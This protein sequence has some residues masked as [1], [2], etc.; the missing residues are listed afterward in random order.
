MSGRKLQLIALAATPLLSLLLS[1]PLAADTL[2]EMKQSGAINFGYRADAAPFSYSGPDG[3]PRGFT[4]AICEKL[5]APL[6]QA[7]GLAS[8]K[9]NFVPVTAADRFAALQSK[10]IDI[11][12]EATTITFK[13]RE[14]MDF[15]LMTFGTG[16]SVLVRSGLKDLKGFLDLKG[17]KIGVLGNTTT[18]EGLRGAL[19]G[20]GV[21]AT[22]E[23]FASHDLGLA[24]IEGGKIDAYFGDRELL[25]G[26]MRKSKAPNQ[27]GIAS[28]QFSYEPYALAMRKGEDRLRLAVDR[29]LAKLYLSGAILEIIDQNFGRR[30]SPELL[31]LYAMQTIPD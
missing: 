24:A 27:L 18:E 11:L 26:L 19:K 14:T 30:P 10:K 15:S 17:R 4:V 28:A 23:T 20:L 7:A 22:I 5:V 3:K 21:E 25:I 29:A 16:A 12:C 8:Y 13:R 6:A 31:M 2:D 9:V 1:P